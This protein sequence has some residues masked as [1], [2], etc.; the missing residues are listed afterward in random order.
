MSGGR[1][2]GRIDIVGLGEDGLDGLSPTARRLVDGAELLVGGA[3]HLA[4]VP[5]DGRERLEWPTPM[6]DA[7][8]TLD[9][10]SRDQRVCVLA[11]GN[12]LWYGAGSLLIRQLGAGRV[13]VVPN[14]SAF[15]LAAARLGWSLA[16]L[17]TLTLHGRSPARLQA[18]VQPG[19][20]LLALSEDAHTPATVA[21]LLRRRG[22]GPSRMW[23]LEHLG[24]P[25]ER[26]VEGTADAWSADGL[27]DLN[28]LAVECVPG[29]EAQVLPCTPGLPDDA[30]QHDGQITKREVRAATLAALAPGPGQHLWDLGAGCGSVAVEWMRAARSTTAE[31]VEPRQDRAALIAENALAL[32]VPGLQIAAGAAPEA[33]AELRA[34]DAVFVGGGVSAPGVLDAAWRALGRGGRLVVNAVTLEGERALLAW[35]AAN[36]GELTRLQVARAEPVGPYH[37]W[38]PAMAVTQLR[39]GKAWGGG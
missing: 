30:F 1:P 12:P 27:A 35:H 29:P 7:V 8:A 6:T 22:F 13:H 38:R 37:G 33:L 9:A 4:L 32:G 2:D 20:R 10:R 39:A 26:V 11:S 17:D 16:D 36:G 24:G 28:T 25:R 34:P 21:E 15:D 5:D 31:A 23:V 19:A 3:R 14:A 18:F